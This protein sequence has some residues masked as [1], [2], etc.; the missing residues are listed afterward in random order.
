MKHRRFI[1]IT[2]F[3]FLLRLPVG[4]GGV[5]NSPR[6]IFLFSFFFRVESWA[7]AHG[8]YRCAVYRLLSE[9]MSTRLLNSISS[10]ICRQNTQFNMYT[11]TSKQQEGCTFKDSHPKCF[12]TR[13]FDKF[14][15][16]AFARGGESR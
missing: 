9:P 8:L 3:E 11:T 1:A 6:S 2:F 12:I 10:R 15:R 7:A 16:E 4:R 14:H 5:I 13:N